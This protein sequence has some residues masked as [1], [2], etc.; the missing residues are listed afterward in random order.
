MIAESHL[1]AGSSSEAC[2]FF[3]G[4]VQKFS[5]LNLYS[6]LW[7]SHHN[8]AADKSDSESFTPV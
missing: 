3:G 7:L 4:G 6:L 1:L 8:K 5:A 2:I